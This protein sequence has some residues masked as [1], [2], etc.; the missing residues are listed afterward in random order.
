MV[1]P[2]ENFNNIFNSIVTIFIL[3][4]QD[5]WNQI[6]QLYTRAIGIESEF[7]W[8]LSI[9]YFLVTMIIGNIVFLALFTSLLLKHFDPE[10]EESVFKETKEADKVKRKR[11]MQNKALSLE[12]T[13][14]QFKK[15]CELT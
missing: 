2:R 3:I 8:Y 9:C 15:C 13:G 5:D 4:M 6:M 12:M 7:N 14:F 11:S 10:D 1:W